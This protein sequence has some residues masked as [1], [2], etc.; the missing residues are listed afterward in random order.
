MRISD[1]SSDVCSSDLRTFAQ[2]A[3]RT[4]RLAGYLAASGLG[5]RRERSELERWECGQSPVALIMGNRP[6]YLESMLGAFRARAVPFNV[7][8]H[9]Q[10][11]EIRSLLRSMGTEAVVYQRRL[12]GVVGAAIEDADLDHLVLVEIDDGSAAPSLPGAVDYEQAIAEGD[13][14]E[15]GRAHV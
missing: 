9:Y 15:I 11:H 10:P 8:H 2:V 6:E 5:V 7:N 4:K 3:D 14:S 13:G 1:W 12:A